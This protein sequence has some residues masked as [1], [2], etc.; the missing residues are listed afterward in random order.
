VWEHLAQADL[1]VSVEE[2]H[3]GGGKRRQPD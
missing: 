2:W 3:D 1:N